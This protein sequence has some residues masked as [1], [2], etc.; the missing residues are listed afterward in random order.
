MML[1][2]ADSVHN[3]PYQLRYWHLLY[4][5]V[6]EGALAG[7]VKLEASPDTINAGQDYNFTIAF[8][9]ISNQTF[10]DSIIA[11]ATLNGDTIN[12]PNLRAIPA[13]DTAIVNIAIPGDKILSSINKASATSNNENGYVISEIHVDINPNNAQPEYTHINNTLTQEFSVKFSAQPVLWTPIS[14]KADNAKVIVSWST[15]AEIN[16]KKFIVFRSANGND[17]DSIG[18]L[19]GAGNSSTMLDYKFTDNTP[20]QGV[21]YYQIKQIDFSGKS[22]ASNIVHITIG[23]AEKLLKIYPNPVSNKITIDFPTTEIVN[24]FVCNTAGKTIANITGKLP[25]INSI[26]TGKLSSIASGVYF[27]ELSDGKDVY[28]TKFIKR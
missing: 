6:P 14:A 28:K 27:V 2:N 7:N 19:K 18:E 26:L 3:T 1:R 25:Q 22:T 17:F 16:N 20:L 10:R 24:V 23:N 5:P 11:S 13:G 21:N 8:K 9:N 15:T 4:T 12:I